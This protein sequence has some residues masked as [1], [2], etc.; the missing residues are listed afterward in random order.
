MTSTLLHLN[1]VE[2]DKYFY[3]FFFSDFTNN[4][5][6]LVFTTNNKSSQYSIIWLP[7]FQNYC[8]NRMQHKQTLAGDRTLLGLLINLA[9]KKNALLCEIFLFSFFW[10]ILCSEKFPKNIFREHFSEN[11]LENTF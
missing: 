5:P 2:N 8:R 7:T 3:T 9:R 4:F 6:G 11:H 10:E 1:K